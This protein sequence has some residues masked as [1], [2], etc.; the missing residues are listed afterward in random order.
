MN[1][2]NL[3]VDELANMIENAK[4]VLKLQKNNLNTAGAAITSKRIEEMRNTLANR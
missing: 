2:N 1:Y 4:I 3:T